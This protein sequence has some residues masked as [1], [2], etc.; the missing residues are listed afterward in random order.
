VVESSGLLNR[1]TVKSCTESS[2]L[3]LSARFFR[4]FEAAEIKPN[5]LVSQASFGYRQGGEQFDERQ[6]ALVHDWACPALSLLFVR[7][8]WL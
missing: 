3:S 4:D 6:S 1:R 2:N 5:P 7:F 8:H